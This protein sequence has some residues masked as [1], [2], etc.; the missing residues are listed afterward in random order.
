MTVNLSALAGA[1]QQF[2]DN[3]GNPL[4]G[5]KLYSYQAGTTTPQSTYTTAAGNIA[6]SNPIILNA[7][8]RVPSGEIWLSVNQNYKFVLDT[9]T[10]QLIATWD[11]ITGIN[12]TGIA[13]NASNVQYDPTGTGAVSTTVQAKLRQTISV[14]D[15]GAVGDGNTDDTT[16]LQNAINAAIAENQELLIDGGTFIASTLTI[17]GSI[18]IKGSGTIKQK[19]N[20]TNNLILVSGTSVNAK[21]F[22]LTFD[23]NQLNQAASGGSIRTI[24]FTSSGTSTEPASIYVENCTFLNGCGYNINV[25]T[26]SSLT[27]V[28]SVTIVNNSFVGGRACDAN[29]DIGYIQIAGPCSYVITGN[30]FN[31]TAGVQTNGGRAGITVFDGFSAAST[32]KAYGVIANNV[33]TNVG[34]SFSI[35]SSGILG[36][37]DVYDWGKTVTIANN[38]LYSPVGRGIQTKADITNL[39]IANNVLDGGYTPGA[40]IVVNSSVNVYANNSVTIIGNSSINS[41]DDS[42]VVTGRNSTNTLDLKDAS[43]I[44]NSIY[45]SGN[46]AINVTD[47]NTV[48]ISGNTIDTTAADGILCTNLLNSINIINNNLKAINTSSPAI[49]LAGGNTSANVSIGNNM[50]DGARFGIR[51]VT[52]NNCSITN[53]FIANSSFQDISIAGI[54]GINQISNN[55][56]TSTDPYTRGTNTGTLQYQ[57]NQTTNAV[58][59]GSR[60]LT[61]ASGVI[62]AVMD[63]HRVDTEGAAATDDLDTIDGGYDGRMLTLHSVNSGRVVTVKDGTGNLRL[64]GDFVMDS[65]FDSITLQWVSSNWYEISRSNNA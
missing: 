51:I 13:T 9:S 45:N 50:I 24:Y 28:E 56:F 58:S 21:F 37:I 23:G 52:C 36:A 8:G 32:D 54:A 7:A 19:A 6:H 12:G 59:V 33:F 15:F 16:A 26:N 25:R 42:I 65:P 34:K 60:N 53:N 5:G 3:D 10:D 39:V 55:V 17:N 14:Q 57:N 18:S 46:R 35:P 1:G 11:N 30:T 62:T 40:H 31:F 43:I 27:S 44:G 2:F 22:G 61:I 49:Y 47:V 20:T 38:V 29:N 48:T 4:A 41:S 64:A 63:W